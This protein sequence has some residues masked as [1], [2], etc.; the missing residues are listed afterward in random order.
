MLEYEKG[1]LF[2]FAFVTKERQTKNCSMF[3]RFNLVAFCEF[4][5]YS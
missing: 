2:G 4:W 3:I 5:R 1:S